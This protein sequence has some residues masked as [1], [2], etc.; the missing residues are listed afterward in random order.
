MKSVL[1]AINMEGLSTNQIEPFENRVI[2]ALK[3][4]SKEYA[5]VQP[6]HCDYK[7][8][9]LRMC[10]QYDIDVVVINEKLQGRG[11]IQTIIKEIKS[12]FPT[13]LIILLLTAERGIGDAFLATM[14]SSGVYNWVSSPWKPEAVANAIISPKKMKDVEVYMPKIVEGKDGLA[15]ETKIVEKKDIPEQLEDLPDLLNLGSNTGI[16]SGAVEDLNVKKENSSSGYSRVIGKARFGFGSAMK[17]K[18]TKQAKIEIAPEQETEIIKEPT[19]QILETIQQKPVVKEEKVETP[20]VEKV[21]QENKTVSQENK[22]ADFKAFVAAR[23]KVEPKVET[24]EPEHVVHVTKEVVKEVPAISV[25]EEPVRYKETVHENVR[26]IPAVAEKPSR[27]EKSEDFNVS[28]LKSRFERA[29]AG[30][31]K[32]KINTEQIPNLKNSKKKLKYNKILFVRAMPLGSILPATICDLMGAE[33]VDFNKKSVNNSFFNDI[34]YTSIKEA[35]LPR[36]EKIVG[37]VVIA[38]GVEKLFPLFDHV[39]L[40]LPEDIFAIKYIVEKHSFISECGVVIDNCRNGIISLNTL[41]KMVPNCLYIDKISID[42]CAKDVYMAYERKQLLN[43]NNLYFN[44]LK[45]LLN[46][47]EA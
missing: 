6:Y 33:F 24:P 41:K 4:G 34:T 5:Q 2:S 14:V 28:E 19:P 27:N 30:E 1:F 16:S 40:I 32:P 43:D 25:K 23:K 7:E 47:L 29:F 18:K 10:S 8:S 35:R 20:V 11:E 39:I 17:P 15:F 22:A 44:S 36:A 45:Y 46:K 21:P 31:N 12:D 3:S 38:N 42:T 13:T 9:V 26:K 37:D